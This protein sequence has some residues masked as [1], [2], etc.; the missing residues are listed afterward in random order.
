MRRIQRL[1][2]LRVGIAV[3]VAIAMIGFVIGVAVASIPASNGAINGCYS[4]KTGALRVIDYPSKR[5]MTGER[6]LRWNQ[7]GPPAGSL[8][9]TVQGSPCTL[10]DGGTA[11]MF[12]EVDR[13]GNV[14]LK[15]WP[16]LTV[17]STTTLA[18]VV[19]DSATSSVAGRTCENAKTCSVAFPPMTSD[20][21]MIVYADR[22]F[23]Y[24]CPGGFATTSFYDAA[25]TRNLGECAGI[26]MSSN[27]TVAITT[28]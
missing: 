5:C 1:N 12:V 21:H 27:R 2:G 20:A 8:Q 25:H 9:A 22:P 11:T 16:V 24:T 17:T 4:T 3:G 14:R 18:R 19:L 7:A 23:A 28:P 15:C 6:F 13:D 10:A 26:V